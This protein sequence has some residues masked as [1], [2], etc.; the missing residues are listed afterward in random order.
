[1]PGAGMIFAK[2]RLEADAGFSV[3]LFNYAP[4]TE[5]LNDVANRLAD[6]IAAGGDDEPAHLVGYSL[7]GVVALRMLAL[8][9]DI[10]IDRVVCL[11][12]PLCGSRSAFRL[13]QLDWGNL[14]LGK[15]IAEGVLDDAAH[16]WAKD[17]TKTHEI[18]CLAG[19]VPL[20]FGRLIAGFD[21]P[22]DGT[23]AVSETRMPG[24]ADH[25][26]L[27]V[28]HKGMLISKDIV[29]QTAAFLRRGEFLREA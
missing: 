17:V 28:S 20:G 22:N 21:E 14:I 16:S 15:T 13:S 4:V 2:M 6:F 29:D 25:L 27:P 26:V 12:S 11:G 23:V 3:A 9:P 10:A 24:I 5:T 19:N 8:R 7:G 1:M 18:G